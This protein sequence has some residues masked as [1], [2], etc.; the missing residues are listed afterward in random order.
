MDIKDTD[1]RLQQLWYSEK[2]KFHYAVVSI[3]E[4]YLDDNWEVRSGN[5]FRNPKQYPCL[6]DEVVMMEMK[7]Y[8]KP[9]VL[10]MSA[11]LQA[12]KDGKMKLGKQ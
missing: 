3:G 1:I 6:P 9:V 2:M 10:K 5:F 11:I 4:P 8:G 12:V 7:P